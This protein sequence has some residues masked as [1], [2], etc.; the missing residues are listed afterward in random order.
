M[1]S[2]KRKETVDGF[3]L[4]LGTNYFGPFALTGLLVPAL[5]R[6]PA[7]R[8]VTVASAAASQGKL[9][10]DD[11]GMQKKYALNPAY[12][13]SKLADLIFAMELQKRLER[14]KLAMMSLASHP[15]YAITNLQNQELSLGIKLIA[16]VLKPIA[17]H[18]AAHGALPTLYAATSGDA[19]AGH[20][21]GP[22]GLLQAKGY[23]TQVAIPQRALDPQLAAKLWSLSEQLTG[24]TYSALT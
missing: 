2:M 22:D 9:D 24:V 1:A 17:S 13:R 15:G 23:P 6:S 3:E 10:L 16:A 8:V 14:A 4:T 7:S 19:K 5:R 20:Y 12:A 18:D 11:M 21:Y